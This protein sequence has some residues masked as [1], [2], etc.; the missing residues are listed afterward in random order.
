M[1]GGGG[2]GGGS[3]V[4][5]ST[6]CLCIDLEHWSVHTSHKVL[7]FCFEAIKIGSSGLN[8]SQPPYSPSLHVRTE[9]CRSEL[10]V[11]TYVHLSPC[12]QV[13]MSS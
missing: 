3:V 7:N 6:V 12:L 9:S 2:G 8:S 4:R 5:G 11:S 1:G 13:S 10:I